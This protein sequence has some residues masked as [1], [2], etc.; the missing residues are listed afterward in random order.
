MAT[1]EPQTIE[2]NGNVT[3][4]AKAISEFMTKHMH[5]EACGK[6]VW[7][8]SLPDIK[9]TCGDDSMTIS[10]A[11]GAL[12]EA[13]S[14]DLFEILAWRIAMHFAEEMAHARLQA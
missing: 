9:I 4:L 10:G 7:K 12:I 8:I 2:Y 13:Q 1:G 5:Y 6:A 11:D 14:D 3:R